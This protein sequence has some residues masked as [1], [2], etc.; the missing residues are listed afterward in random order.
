MVKFN[1][2][3]GGILL[4]SGTTIGAGMLALPVLTSFV[5]FF[6]SIL[7]FLVCWLV[8]LATAYFFL[9]VNFAVKGEPNLISMTHK[10][11]GLWGKIVAWV[12]YI[13]LLYSLLAAYIAGSVPVFSSAIEDITGWIIPAWLGPFALPLI[14]GGFVYLGTL[15]VDL[16][17]RLLMFGLV[18]SYLLLV[19]VLPS[20]IQA[21]N[22][23][24]IDWAPSL[25]AIPVVITSFGYHIIIPT[26]TTYMNHDKKHL[27][28]TLLIGSLVPLVIYLLWQVMILGIVPLEGKYSLVHAWKLGVP[29]TEPLVMM[30]QQ[31]W[32]GI[33]ARFFM[34]FAIVTSFLG[35]SLSLS[36]FLTDGLKIKKSWEGRLLACLLVFVPPLFFVF[37]YQR[38]FILALQYAGAFVAVL[39]IFLPS[40]MAW[41][42]KTPKFYQT[43]KAK[44]LMLSLMLFSAFVVV[45]VLLQQS[46]VLKPL[47]SQYVQA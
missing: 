41:K 28:L 7:I 25:I 3:L 10:T 34:F 42:L 45:L 8:M 6:P 11:L 40:M 32:I 22:L 24:H 27:R 43:K 9:D 2:F 4:V 14:F 20:H 33:G 12:F 31:K 19:G 15:G 5:G 17:N 18:L 23:L 44:I 21:E 30:L 46:G 16:I 13:L 47:I 26:L 35:V 38:G 39:L 37:I 1:H 36:D 29:S